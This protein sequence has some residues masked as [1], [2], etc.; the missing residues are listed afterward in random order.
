MFEILVG[1]VK[2][3]SGGVPGGD[4]L[5][6][7]YSKGSGQLAGYYGL[8]PA[9]DL[10]TGG[11][12][13]AALPAFS[14][15]N[16]IANYNAGWLKFLIDGKI[17]Y[18]AKKPFKYYV[19][20]DGVNTTAT[21]NNRLTG[22]SI[23]IGK[24][25]YLL[26]SIKGLNGDSQAVPVKTDNSEWNRLIYSV[27]SPAISGQQVT[28][29]VKWD[30]FTYADLGMGVNENGRSTICMELFIASGTIGYL[31]RGDSNDAT[32]SSGET[33]KSTTSSQYGWRPVLELVS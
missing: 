13:I 17:I 15:T 14:G 4:T 27:L 16:I 29:G 22:K 11:D 20:W 7:S 8:V 6:Y 32:N 3:A 10:I 33:G 24:Y 31:Y 26:R 19:S 12:L 25:D 18:V 30:N 5:L 21:S 2:K 1:G 28:G 9:S 23:T